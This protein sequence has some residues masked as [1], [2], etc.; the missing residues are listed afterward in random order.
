MSNTS[1]AVV[2]RRYEPKDS[3]EDWPTPPW[4]TRALV[5]HVLPFVYFGDHQKYYSELKKMTVWESTCNRGYMVR[6]LREYF[7]RTIA[8]DV[9]DYSPETDDMHMLHDFLCP[10]L[11]EII[12]RYP[13]DFVITNPPFKLA[14]QF[15][16]RALSIRS[17]KF[18]A[19]FVRANFLEGKGRFQNLFKVNPPALFAPFVERVPLVK[20]RVD[21]KASSTTAYCW[22][23]WSKGCCDRTKVVW[24]P[25]C[26][27]DLERPDDYEPVQK[28][29]KLETPL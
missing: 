26:R 6:P 25:P 19:F 20:E 17:V 24:I 18:C 7:G 1:T 12:E 23:V 21:P 14:E 13:P 3:L 5:K 8:T 2:N 9:H 28:M 16:Q 27:N 10:E 22:L 4:A 15:V 29:H 11:P